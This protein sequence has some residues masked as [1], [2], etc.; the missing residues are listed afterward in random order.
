MV[1]KFKVPIL[2]PRIRWGSLS[3]WIF[4]FDK[5]P[6]KV[7]LHIVSGLLAPISDV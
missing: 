6:E 1:N 5:F 7:T 4:L 3:P 2:Q